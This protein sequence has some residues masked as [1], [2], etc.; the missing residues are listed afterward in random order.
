[1]TKEV[2]EGSGDFRIGG[3]V[4]RSVKYADDLVLVLLAGNERCCRALLTRLMESGRCCVV[5][6]NV[7][8]N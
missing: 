6:R 4:I 8:K 3:R 1:M 2:L 7:G 5:E